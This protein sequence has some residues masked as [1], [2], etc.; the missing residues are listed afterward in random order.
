M[1]QQTHTYTCFALSCMP[2]HMTRGR[3]QQDLCSSSTCF[4]AISLESLASAAQP[5]PDFS[6][7]SRS[8]GEVALGFPEE[9][10]KLDAVNYRYVPSIIDI[11]WKTFA[12]KPSLFDIGSIKTSM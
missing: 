9:K 6:A 3:K 5:S 2:S 11:R 10:K 4:N 1:L 12:K 8:N 7:F